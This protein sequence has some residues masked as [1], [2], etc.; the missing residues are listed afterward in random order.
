MTGGRVFDWSQGDKDYDRIL[1]EERAT[2]DAAEV[3]MIALEKRGLTQSALAEACNINPGALSQRINGRANMTVRLLAQRDGS[4][5]PGHIRVG[6][7]RTSS[8][9]HARTYPPLPALI[10]S[11]VFPAAPTR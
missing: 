1:A 10:A 11:H 2:V 4:E 8:A 7:S 9:G 5:H 3:V 6:W